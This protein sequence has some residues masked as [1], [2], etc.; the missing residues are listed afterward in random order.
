M[1]RS[2]ELGCRNGWNADLWVAA[3]AEGTDQRSQPLRAIAGRAASEV[4]PAEQSDL[5]TSIVAAKTENA[6]LAEQRPAAR[7]EPAKPFIEED[8][9]VNQSPVLS[10]ARPSNSPIS[11]QTASDLVQDPKAAILRARDQ[12]R[13]R[14]KTEGRLA[15]LR[16][17]DPT[18][19]YLASSREAQLIHGN[20]LEQ[21]AP[22]P[23]TVDPRY[24]NRPLLRPQP[25]PAIGFSRPVSP[26]SMQEVERPFPSMTEFPEDRARFESVP[27]L[28]AELDEI[29]LADVVQDDTW[30]ETRQVDAV[31][32]EP[33]VVD[34]FFEEDELVAESAPAVYEDEELSVHHRESIINRLLR[35]RRER[36]KHLD[37][38]EDGFGHDDRDVRVAESHPMASGSSSSRVL[39]GWQGPS[40]VIQ[41]DYVGVEA[42]GWLPPAPAEPAHRAEVSPGRGHDV[43]HP[44]PSEAQP[45]IETSLRSGLGGGARPNEQPKAKEEDDF[46]I[47]PPL[48]EFRLDEM[49][50]TQA[51]ENQRRPRVLPVREERPRAPELSPRPVA[52]EFGDQPLFAAQPLLAG[53]DFEITAPY[54]RSDRPSFV[55]P[56]VERVCQTCRDFR[57]SDTGERGWC[58]NKW[59]FNHRRMV[60]A[61]DLACRNSLGSWWTPKDES[62][63]RDGDIS[64]H[65]Q[66]TP[67]VDQWL[68][69]T[70]EID[71]DRRRSGS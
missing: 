20:D 60:D 16:L 54:Q 3:S 63:R 25:T 26:V 70:R 69:G 61:D 12:F 4:G 68:L 65:A 23:G 13:Q 62:W 27:S 7:P 9:I 5:I 17:A 45:P 10:W 19:T 11:P 24:E 36:R 53:E 34:D 21:P 35:Q 30:I 49:Q 33:Y 59:A 31:L 8:I 2:N 52:D 28:E 14:R 48:P 55:A 58:N 18:S 47:P 43:H 50:Q 42:T 40:P 41:A 44:Q 66:Q 22:D 39:D 64:R 37:Y 57:P 51:F 56:Q 46:A 71:S 15:D 32:P 6:S 38:V 1:V 29:D 67:R